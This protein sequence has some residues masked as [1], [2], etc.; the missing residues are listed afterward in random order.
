M[1]SLSAGPSGGGLAGLCRVSV[2]LLLLC[3]VL[4]LRLRVTSFRVL[5][6]V[7]IVAL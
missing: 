3:E 1:G 7:G 2:A 5:A 6:K 4:E